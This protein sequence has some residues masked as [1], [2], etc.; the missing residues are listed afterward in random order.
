MDLEPV[1]SVRLSPETERR[2]HALA[3]RT[4]RS[5]GFYAR[6]LIEENIDDLEDRYLVE[7]SLN[8]PGPNLTTA[9]VRKELGLDD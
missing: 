7:Q 3:E 4:G 2:L 8:E 6:A 5:I 9:E 1:L